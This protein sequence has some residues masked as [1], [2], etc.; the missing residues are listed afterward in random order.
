[1]L[2]LDEQYDEID[3]SMKMFKEKNEQQK[4]KKKR[5]HTQTH[6]HT[7]QERQRKDQI[8]EYHRLQKSQNKCYYCLSSIKRKQTKHL[9]VSLGKCVVCVF[10]C[11]CVCVLFVKKRTFE[12]CLYA[13]LLTIQNTYTLFVHTHTR[14]LTHT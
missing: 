13:I 3:H 14:T 10:V 9:I 12:L 11:V 6:T 5:G 8:N 4:K 7:Q 2:D 1:V